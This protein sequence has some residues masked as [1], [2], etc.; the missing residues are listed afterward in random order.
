MHS[1]HKE[2][3]WKNSLILGSLG[4]VFGDIGTSPL[5]AMRE[6]LRGLTIEPSNIIGVLSLIFWTL[7]LVVSV[8]YLA[9]IFRADNEGEGGAFALLALLKEKTKYQPFL[10]LFAI[11]SAGLLVGDGMLTPAIS[12]TSAI[13][14]LEVITPGLHD[15]IILLSLVILLSLFLVQP[16]GTGIIGNAFGPVICVWFL[17]IALLGLR[18]VI[19]NPIVLQAVNPYFAYH[20]FQ[21]NGMR[22]YLLLGGVFLVV[23]GGEALYADIGHFGKGPIRISWFFVV[24]PALLLNYFGQGADLLLNPSHIQN[25]FYMIAP[26]WFS[27]PLV[28]LASMA[29]V[30][31]SQAVISATFSMTKQAVM[32]GLFPR[33]PIRQTS[34][35]QRGQIYIPQINFFLLIGTILLILL[36]KN[37]SHLTHAYGIAVNLLML[38]MTLMVGYTSR[39]VWHWSLFKS[40]LVFIPFIAIDSLFLGANFDKF[41]TGGWVPISLAIL[42]SSIMYTWSQ[43]MRFLKKNFYIPEEDIAVIVKQLTQPQYHQVSGKIGVCI[44][45]N[46]DNSGG[47]FLQFFKLMK[48]VPENILIVNYVVE[49]KPYI[50]LTS[51]FAINITENKLYR[52]TLHFGFMD[53]IA[54][55]HALKLLNEQKLLPFFVDTDMETY[56]VEILNVVA[57]KNKRTLSYFWQERLFA[58]LVRNYSM[59]LNIQF[60]KL[61][62][63]RTVAIGSFCHM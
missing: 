7:I 33:L 56:L 50:P 52:L 38:M 5:Y 18:Q 22:A 62:Y 53:D 57:S 35:H 10:Y 48:I 2:H 13:E 8:K 47:N 23:T 40:A 6:T 4:V 55:P 34:R 15:V 11:F 58:F 61:P 63:R 31:A 46:Y 28:I 16:K 45:D 39:K 9:I 12:V 59:N 17:A 44:T 49:H 24:L 14:G 41:A 25:P 42:V 21:E 60:F 1:K 26:S 19:N 37:S 20:F 51:R 3:F 36:F 43:G 29:T 54:I 30:I 32:L 27:L